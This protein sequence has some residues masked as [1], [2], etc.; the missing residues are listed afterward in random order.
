MGPGGAYGGGRGPGWYPGYGAYVAT[1]CGY[2]SNPN[3]CYAP[4]Y[5]WYPCPYYNYG[6]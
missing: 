3:N 4:G 2:Y 6:Y 1:R 5:G